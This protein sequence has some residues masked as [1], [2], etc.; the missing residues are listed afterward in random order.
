[1]NKEKP[2][3]FCCE[4]KKPIYSGELYYWKKFDREAICE[5]CCNGVPEELMSMY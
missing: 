4:C 5:G 2:S 3:L 1:M